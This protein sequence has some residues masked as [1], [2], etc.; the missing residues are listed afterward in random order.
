M[1]EGKK[2]GQARVQ[3]KG[4]ST[5]GKFG[6]LP[7]SMLETVK[8]STTQSVVCRSL[9]CVTG[10]WWNKVLVAKSLNPLFTSADLSFTEPFL[11][12]GSSIQIYVLAQAH[13]VLE[14]KEK[15]AYQLLECTSIDHMSELSWLGEKKL[16]YLYHIISNHCFRPMP[17]G[18]G[19]KTPRS[20][21]LWVAVGVVCLQPVDKIKC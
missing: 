21:G 4:T 1:K 6:S 16:N 5:Q 10:P 12:E 18:C 20:P 14:N 9:I 11:S 13:L 3:G 2:W 15:F 19:A 7:Q 8:G 17:W